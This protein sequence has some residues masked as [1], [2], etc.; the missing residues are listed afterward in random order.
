MADSNYTSGLPGLAPPVP[1]S[2]I[3]KSPL[4]TRDN[5]KKGINQVRQTVEEV[6]QSLGKKSIAGIQQAV[7]LYV[8]R[9]EDTIDLDSILVDQYAPPFS[10]KYRIYY[11][12]PFLHQCI[13]L[14]PSFRNDDFLRH[15]HHL[16]TL[17]KTEK[18]ASQIKALDPG[19]SKTGTVLLPS[20]IKNR[21]QGS[22]DTQIADIFGGDLSSLKETAED[23]LLI[24]CHPS[25]VFV[26]S[27]GPA[28][29]PA[30]GDIISIII[31]ERGFLQGAYM[32]EILKKG[33]NNTR[34]LFHTN[35]I[36]QNTNLDDIFNQD[37]TPTKLRD[38]TSFKFGP[39]AWPASS[40]YTP[41][42]HA[43]DGL[44]HKQ[45]DAI[46]LRDSYVLAA[47]IK[48]EA[49]PQGPRAIRFEANLFMGDQNSR[50]NAN[51]LAYS[52]K[53]AKKY[54]YVWRNISVEGQSR[55]VS[56]LTPI[57][58]NN[59]KLIPDNGKTYKENIEHALTDP[60]GLIQTNG[61]IQYS[62]QESFFDFSGTTVKEIIKKI[63][64]EDV[65]VYETFYIPGEEKT[66]SVSD[67]TKANI[68]SAAFLKA[69][70]KDPIRA[71]KSTSFGQFQVM[72]WALLDLYDND[73]NIAL[74]AFLEDP[75]EVAVKMLGKFFQHP[76]KKE[77][78]TIINANFP[79]SPTLDQWKGFAKLYN[80][81]NCCDGGDDITGAAIK[82]TTKKIYHIRIKQDY[83]AV[84]KECAALKAAAPVD[85]TRA[86][87]G[88][89]IFVGPLL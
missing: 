63:N 86:T 8:K 82:T 85:Y 69:F 26:P 80:G 74:N 15:I 58:A 43:L 55:K 57:E 72:G 31:P 35:E 2:A 33:L 70:A 3:L 40:K 89:D 23:E 22:P 4:L 5:I 67:H 59:V 48:K 49:G 18:G 83:E 45:A 51:Q 37:L 73:P 68:Q 11:R 53:Q 77:A 71:I 10:E 17:V 64:G 62:P 27:V 38:L 39:K 66:N 52:P 41:C 81:P 25:V 75:E 19:T 61:G 56:F 20:R 79:K 16:G 34:M 46:G 29:I 28:A 65:T 12:I 21:N 9:L 6:A 7:V 13:P 76:D 78:I 14:P 44:L 36:D 24:L 88:P 60:S 42:V 30:I 1:N 87:I 54:G 32:V 50:K 84:K 47:I